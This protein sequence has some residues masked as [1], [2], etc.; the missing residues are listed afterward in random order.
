MCTA[1]GCTQ[2]ICLCLL[3]S[4]VQ[5][6]SVSVAFWEIMRLA[7]FWVNS[8]K[9][10]R[11][12]ELSDMMGN[13]LSVLKYTLHFL[14][15]HIW[16]LDNV[17]FPSVHLCYGF[18]STSFEG[19]EIHKIPGYYGLSPTLLDF[20]SFVSCWVF[21]ASALQKSSSSIKQG[22]VSTMWVLRKAFKSWAGDVV[23]HCP[24]P[25]TGRATFITAL[26]GMLREEII[27]VKVQHTPHKATYFLETL[28]AQHCKMR[29]GL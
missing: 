2:C 17:E 11:L 4:L 6:M 8:D 10:D 19:R 7:R 26:V 13:S 5:F 1:L 28:V 20:A 22:L 9:W 16:V 25:D 29:K 3:T 18:L 14:Q 21:T 12:C 27:A 24:L 23:S 15:S